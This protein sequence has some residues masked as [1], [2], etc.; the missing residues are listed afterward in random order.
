MAITTRG[1][2]VAATLCL[3]LITGCGDRPLEKD[4]RVIVDDG[5]AR[6]A[7][8]DVGEKGCEFFAYI[9]ARGRRV[10]FFIYRESSGIYR[11]A[12]DACRECY[13]W[14]KGYRLRE[15]AVV[16]RKCG[17][18]FTFDSLHEGRGSCTPIALSSSLEGDFLAIPIAELEAGAKYF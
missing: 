2:A 14:H 7:L 12:L 3:T 16:C 13:R 17:E 9:T 18:T 1:F 8:A 10:D 6:V 15:G 5:T 4:A 11:A